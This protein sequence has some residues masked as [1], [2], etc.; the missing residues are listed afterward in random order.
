PPA[1]YK[2]PSTLAPRLTWPPVATSS[3]CTTPEVEIHPPA[4]KAS[5]ADPS[6]TTFEPAMKTSLPNVRVPVSCSRA[7]APGAARHMHRHMMS[8][9]GAPPPDASVIGAHHTDGQ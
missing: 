7:E 9:S 6:V 8:V 1:A 5:P 3:P 2:L 4:S